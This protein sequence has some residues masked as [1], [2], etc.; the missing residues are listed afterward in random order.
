MK[1][2]GKTCSRAPDTTY[3][4]I[5]RIPMNKFGNGQPDFNI[6]ASYENLWNNF[7][8]YLDDT[9]FDDLV[10]YVRGT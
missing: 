10:T 9:V 1:G 6:G 2:W 8:F 7:Y 4:I 5:F 3:G